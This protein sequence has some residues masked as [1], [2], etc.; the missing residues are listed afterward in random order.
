MYHHRFQLVGLSLL[1]NVS[2][3]CCS[4]T[5]LCQLFVTPWTAALQASLSRTIYRSFSKFM[6]I[7]SVMLSS[8]LIL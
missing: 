6:F 5:Q 3:R 2:C 1:Y 7:A 8:H 4:V